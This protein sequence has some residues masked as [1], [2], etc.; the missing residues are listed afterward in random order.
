MWNIKTPETNKTYWL[1]AYPERAP[2]RVVANVVG[3]IN[4]HQFGVSRMLANISSAENASRVSAVLADIP[5]TISTNWIRSIVIY[6]AESRRFCHQR[7]S[8]KR[9]LHSATEALLWWLVGA[10]DVIN[11]LFE[12]FSGKI[13][14]KSNA[15]MCKNPTRNTLTR[16]PQPWFFYFNFFLLNAYDKLGIRHSL[17]KDNCW[18]DRRFWQRFY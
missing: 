7:L 9:A 8:V 11:V 2:T 12:D 18:I 5:P 4:G 3:V 13:A 15:R 6:F 16:M 14:V 17:C 10:V 1:C